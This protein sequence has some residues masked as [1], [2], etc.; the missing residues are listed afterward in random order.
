MLLNKDIVHDL[1][2]AAAQATG[3]VLGVM[4]AFS[5]VGATAEFAIGPKDDTRLADGS[6]SLTTNEKAHL[7]GIFGPD[8]NTEDMRVYF[9]R[10]AP[11]H[12]NFA[13]N[14]A[15][16]VPNGNTTD[17][18]MIA[19]YNHS[20]D[21]TRAGR[22][23][24]QYHYGLLVH[25]ATHNWQNA[26]RLNGETVKN[27]E[28]ENYADNYD[29][30]L[31]ATS[32]MGDFCSEQQAEIISHYAMRFLYADNPARAMRA[33]MGA[34]YA[35]NIR[36]MSTDDQN[37]IRVVE[38][39]LP[40]ARATRRGIEAQFDAAA[41]CVRHTQEIADNP[42][43]NPISTWQSCATNLTDLDGSFNA[44]AAW[45]ESHTTSDQPVLDET[46][47]RDLIAQVRRVWNRSLG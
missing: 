9:H 33:A 41:R 16:Y 24:S 11:H 42:Y 12:R 25:E 27:C 47:R 21:Y 5:I 18:H 6:R 13:V 29:Y 20:H 19:D 46:P 4:G 31:T 39:A 8:F 10:E 38:E 34:T 30:T 7:H 36:F 40:A 37:L 45:R 43:L 14:P 28:N 17:M 2:T 32:K 23:N 3:M 44:R 22:I 1:A 26:R 15:A 35:E